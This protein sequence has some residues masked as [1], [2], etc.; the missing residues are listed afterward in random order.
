MAKREACI[1][2]D[3]RSACKLLYEKINLAEGKL[4]KC[5]PQAV[6]Y[7]RKLQSL[8][9]IERMYSLPKDP[10]NKGHGDHAGVPNKSR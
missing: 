6:T 1:S 9:R 8:Y 3:Y 4:F 10:N 2:I 5:I 7:R